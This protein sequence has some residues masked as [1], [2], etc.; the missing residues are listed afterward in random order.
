[1][2]HG[3]MEDFTCVALVKIKD[4]KKTEQKAIVNPPVCGVYVS[5]LIRYA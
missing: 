2:F 5:K 3:F 1:M 4:G